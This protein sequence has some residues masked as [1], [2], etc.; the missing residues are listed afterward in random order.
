[1]AWGWGD[2]AG[3]CESL[4]GFFE[5]STLG[6]PSLGGRMVPGGDG[7]GW[8]RWVAPHLWGEA[9]AHLCLFSLPERKGVVDEV[10]RAA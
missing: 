5:L 3:V 6:A 1:M 7:L 4:K 2:N 8:W 10:L 9:G